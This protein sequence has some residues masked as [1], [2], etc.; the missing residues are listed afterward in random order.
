MQKYDGKQ[1]K[2]G[3]WVRT[4]RSSNVFGFIELTDGTHFKASRLFSRSRILAT[5]KK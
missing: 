3:G 1:I 4:L 2:T 5:I